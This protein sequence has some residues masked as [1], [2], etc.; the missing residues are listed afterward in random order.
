MK[1]ISFLTI[2]LQQRISD[3]LIGS[4]VM[5]S[6]N[7]KT[8]RVDD[9]DWNTTAS[10]TFDLRGTQTSFLNYFRDKY[11][12]HIRDPGQPLLV[13][14][15]KKK[16]IHRGMTGPILLIPELCQMTGITDEMRANNNLMKAIAQYLHTDPPV[17]VNKI[18]DFMQ[19][20]KGNHSV[21]SNQEYPIP[22]S[23]FI[24]AA[25]RSFVKNPTQY[26]TFVS[27]VIVD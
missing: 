25:G 26:P 20:M 22:A 21:S 9:I 27:N 15:P 11:N 6:Y 4:I 3:E 12:I 7:R 19:R 5:T 16:D 1:K 14:R 24:K 8:Y 17:R 2:L 13:S 23:Q 10:S 18:K